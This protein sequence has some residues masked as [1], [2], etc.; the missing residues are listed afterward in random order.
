MK[1]IFILTLYIIVTDK[2]VV[3]NFRSK[4]ELVV[5]LMNGYME[6]W[7]GCDRTET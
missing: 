1:Y 3:R 2:P 6:C 7:M 4:R 5:V